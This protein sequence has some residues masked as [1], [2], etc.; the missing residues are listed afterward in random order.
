[1][2]W[3][4]D[5]GLLRHGCGQCRCTVCGE[6][7]SSAGFEM[8]RVGQVGSHDRRCLT[9]PE[10]LTRGMGKCARG[11]WVTQLHD[12]DT[13]A[14]VAARMRAEPASACARGVKAG[15]ALVS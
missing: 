5:A 2:F 9:V 10:M 4:D 12:E 15:K 13:R 7:F 14:K 3:D 11:W 8:H 6:Y 1:M